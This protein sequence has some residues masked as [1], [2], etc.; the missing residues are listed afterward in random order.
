MRTCSS[1]PSGHTLGLTELVGYAVNRIRGFM[2][3]FWIREP[4]AREPYYKY[5]V[6][7]WGDGHDCDTDGNSNH[8]D[9]RTWTELTIINRKDESERVDV[10]PISDSPLTLEVKSERDYLAAR[11]AYALAVTTAGRLSRFPDGSRLEN[12]VLVPL[13]GQFD[14]DAALKRSQ[15]TR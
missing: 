1:K 4:G 14:L 7:L 12:T 11:L 10:D 6:F 13:M 3:R 8:I 9:D 5:M 15:F 2:I